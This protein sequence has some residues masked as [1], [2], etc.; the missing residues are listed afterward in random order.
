MSQFACVPA[1]TAD[2]QASDTKGFGPVRSG[3]DTI[4]TRQGHGVVRAYQ[5]RGLWGGV[6]GDAIGVGT[7]QNCVKNQ[8]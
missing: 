1:F 6:G 7:S 3:L 4:W 2:D 5:R 8:G